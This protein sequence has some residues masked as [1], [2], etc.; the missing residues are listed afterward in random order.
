MGLSLYSDGSISEDVLYK[1]FI[2][3]LNT[4]SPI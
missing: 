3:F 1:S 2:K 4:N